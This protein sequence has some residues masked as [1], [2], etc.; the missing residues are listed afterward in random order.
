MAA[1][2]GVLGLTLG[3]CVQ[4]HDSNKAVELVKADGFDGAEAKVLDGNSKPTTLN[5]QI[6]TCTVNGVG[7]S[8]EWTDH[9]PVDIRGYSVTLDHRPVR[10][11]SRDEL[12]A[13]V[14]QLKVCEQ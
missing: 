11:E 4:D 10:F 2:G 8:V 9:N 3:G 1:V 13:Q 5:L 6:G 14:P 7:A 12:V